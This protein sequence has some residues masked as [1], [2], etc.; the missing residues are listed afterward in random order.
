MKTS[1]NDLHHF[2]SDFVRVFLLWVMLLNQQFKFCD[3][4]IIYT[5]NLHFEHKQWQLELA[6]WEVEL[7][8]FKNKLSE[9][10]THWTSKDVPA[11]LEHF[12]NEIILHGEIMKK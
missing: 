10:V 8:L 3:Y 2:S 11:K 6:Y 5:T 1:R 4:E 7:K 9:L 12:L